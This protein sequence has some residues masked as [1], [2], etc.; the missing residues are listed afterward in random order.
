MTDFKLTQ[1]PRRREGKYP[2]VRDSLGRYRFAGWD[3]WL[4]RLPWGAWQ[5]LVR[6]FD[7]SQRCQREA[8]P[9]T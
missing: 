9:E 3:R 2:I 7:A 6:R 4:R 1:Q 8:C 5:S